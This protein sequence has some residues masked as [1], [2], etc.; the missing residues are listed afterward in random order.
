MLIPFFYFLNMV[1]FLAGLLSL[2]QGSGER[3]FSLVLI[4]ALLCIPLLAVEY[5]YL[6]HRLEAQP[7]QL[8][9]FSELVFLLIWLSLALRLQQAGHSSLHDHRR[10]FV[11][12][13]VAGFILLVLAGYFL[14]THNVVSV[15][16]A[17]IAFEMYD[18][19]FFLTLLMLLVVFFTAW[20]LEEFW[21][22]LGSQAR[23]EYKFLIIGALVI[24]GTLAWASSY[25]LT[26]LK[27][28]PRH[29][30]L[31]STLLLSGWG[32]MVYA[33]ARHR[34]LNR[35]IFVS[36][37][38]VYSILVP[39]LL[40]AYLL[41]FGV[42]SLVI[43]AFGLE[44]SYVLKWLFLLLGLFVVGL[45]GFSAS[46]RRR[47]QYFISTHFYINKYE[48]R[49]EW[50]AL[51]QEFQG[52][53]TEDEVVKAL[54][55]VLTRSLY[56]SEIFIWTGGAEHKPDYV[57]M[58]SPEAIEESDTG[59]TIPGSDILVRYLQNHAYFHRQ[60]QEP[61]RLWQKVHDEKSAFFSFF[62]LQLLVP[63]VIGRNFVGIIGLGPE[64]TGGQ[65]GHDDFDLLTALGSQTASALLA[66]RMAEE[67]AFAREQQAWDRLSA[68]VLHDIKNSATM[69][70]LLQENAPAH[71]HEPEF[72]RDMLELVDDA[73]KRMAR[74]EQR[75]GS[76]REEI[77]PNLKEVGLKTFLEDVVYRMQAK[78]PGLEIRLDGPGEIPLH[79]DPQLL[80]TIFENI[81]LNAYEAQGKGGGVQIRYYRDERGEQVHVE[82]LDN[83]PGIAQDLLPDGI[84][85]PFKTSKEG[86]SGI[87]LW[88]AKRVAMSLR[89][90]ITAENGTKGGACFVLGLP[91]MDGEEECNYSTPS[92][93]AKFI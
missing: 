59:T 88:Q 10:A 18:L 78:L 85:E 47:A 60:E 40:S 31:L 86:G 38:I 50:L 5:F 43:R 55:Q 54:R 56:T 46:F 65:Y 72:Q 9:L 2:R 7:V 34:L 75:L 84:F 37:K 52:A 92:K 77:V 89:A 76:L 32:M 39:S 82:I 12:E 93:S 24:C 83:G 4:Q 13:F 35:K 41:G 67:L 14:A 20:R 17:S 3:N 11:L 16:Q 70:S 71:I 25:R 29:L 8:V 62:N 44:M 23:W 30:L 48:Y 79:S 64:F 69:L 63:I 51:S 73:L 66:V 49:D 87:G 22:A 80:H 1:L 21:R 33:V 57:L 61:D 45:F 26:Y 42:I 68:F 58:S 81:L 6:G 19:V 53:S 74:V 28:F 90:S 27:I 91:Q 15:V 36:R